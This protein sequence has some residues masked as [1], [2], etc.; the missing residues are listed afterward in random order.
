MQKHQQAGLAPIS[1]FDLK[2]TRVDLIQ[3]SATAQSAFVSLNELEAARSSRRPVSASK[4]GLE[5]ICGGSCE[6]GA[7]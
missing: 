1:N 5:V 2:N 3:S 6:T 7:Q 4:H